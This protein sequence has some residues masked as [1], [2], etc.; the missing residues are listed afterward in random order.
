MKK[1]GPL[2]HVIV[3]AALLLFLGACTSRARPTPVLVIPAEPVEVPAQTPI[4]VVPAEP[5]VEPTPEP[6]LVQPADSPL[7][8]FPP[9]PT[10]TAPQV[11][12]VTATPQIIVVLPETGADLASQRAASLPLG[13]AAMVILGASLVAFGLLN[14]RHE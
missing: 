5:L 10:S 11:I 3:S 7:L 2:T 13:P 12:F 4:F 14:R 1:V 9:T 6:V 8:P